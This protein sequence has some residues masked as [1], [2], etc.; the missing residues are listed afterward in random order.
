M[1]TNYLRGN[2]DGDSCRGIRRALY[3]N[4]KGREL[5]MRTILLIGYLTTTGCAAHTIETHAIYTAERAKRSHKAE[6]YDERLRLA[7]WCECAGECG[8]DTE[9][10]ACDAA[11]GVWDWS[12]CEGGAW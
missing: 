11:Y 8:T 12:D 9:C 5:I 4:L 6:T 1:G 3:V 7:A 2:S 10:E